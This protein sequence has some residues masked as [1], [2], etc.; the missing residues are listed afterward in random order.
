MLKLTGHRYYAFYA[1]LATVTLVITIFP[2]LAYLPLGGRNL[3]LVVLSAVNTLLT[4]GLL[5]MLYKALLEFHSH[6]VGRGLGNGTDM[7]TT[8][9]AEDEAAA[10]PATGLTL[11]KCALEL[12]YLIDTLNDRTGTLSHM[13]SYA[14]S[15][16]LFF[17]VTPLFLQ[18]L[19]PSV[20]PVADNTPIS[21]INFGTTFFYGMFAVLLLAPIRWMA[22]RRLAKYRF[23][24]RSVDRILL[25]CNE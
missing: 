5:I 25:D 20:N 12:K 17:Y 1:G 11:R 23:W 2:P 13:L 3:R 8:A 16:L 24:L 21:V 22:H 14:I 4:V 7:H 18:L 10:P 15:A 6:L 19:L 9:C